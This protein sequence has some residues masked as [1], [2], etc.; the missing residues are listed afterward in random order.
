[1]A[2]HSLGAVVF[3]VLIRTLS[4]RAPFSSIPNLDSAPLFAIVSV[5]APK[6][7]CFRIADFLVFLLFVRNVFQ[8]GVE[9]FRS[10][11]LPPLSILASFPT[12]T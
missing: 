8:H 6:F 10:Y 2:Q 12:E 1:M 4:I 11:H 7:T 5:C 3:D 9:N